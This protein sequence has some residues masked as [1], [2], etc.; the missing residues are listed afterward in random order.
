MWEAPEFQKM[1]YPKGWSWQTLEG[2]VGEIW[3]DI[4]GMWG[5]NGGAQNSSGAQPIVDPQ[6]NN[7]DSPTQ[8]QIDVAVSIYSG[9]LGAGNDGHSNTIHGSYRA[10]TP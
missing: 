8:A 6:P 3:R 10:W 4:C 5:S 9:Y 2:R 7:A 1:D